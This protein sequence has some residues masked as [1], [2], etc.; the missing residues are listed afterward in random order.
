MTGG[1]RTWTALA[2]LAALGMGPGA[3]AELAGAPRSGYQYLTPETREMQDDAFA[4][5]GMAAVDEGRKRFHEPGV[6]GKTC[7][8]CH[9]EDGSKLDPGGIAAFP[10]WN[11]EWEEP[12]TLQKQINFCWEE[13]LDN[14]P[15]VADCPDLVELEAFVRHLAKGEPVNVDVEGELK[16]YYEAGKQLYHTR[17]GL[18][19]MAC[20]VCHDQ[21][22]GQHLR[23]Q[24]LSQGHSNG[25]PEY[26]LGS[27]K[28]TALHARIDEC[29]RSF[30]AEPFDRGSPEFINLEIYLHA[31]GNGLPIETPAVR[32]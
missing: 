28:M 30:G 11:A 4:N 20:N 14:V 24:V 29:F 32:Y 9:G 26:R 27:G 6:N 7:A 8:S 25:F 16:P 17:F 18:M 10:R 12:F 23:G 1:R 22:A 19:N 2:A 15:Y 3:L 5:P 31:R 13:H 21:Y